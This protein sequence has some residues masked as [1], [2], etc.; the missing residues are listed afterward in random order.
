MDFKDSRKFFLRSNV[1]SCVLKNV[2]VQ[3]YVAMTTTHS[4]VPLTVVSVS[5]QHEF[6]T[7]HEL[8]VRLACFKVFI[9]KH[10]THC[11]LQSTPSSTFRLPQGLSAQI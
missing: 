6:A 8:T 3:H 9:T 5:L 1:V 4:G 11:W 2:Y 10:P 7:L